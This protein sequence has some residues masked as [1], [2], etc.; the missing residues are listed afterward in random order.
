MIHK[1]IRRQIWAGEDVFQKQCSKMSR[2][3]F[4]TEKDANAL[5]RNLSEWVS[6]LQQ[7][8]KKESINPTQNNS[9]YNRLGPR[10][11]FVGKFSKLWNLFQSSGWPLQIGESVWGLTMGH[12]NV[13]AVWLQNPGNLRFVDCF[14]REIRLNPSCL[15]DFFQHIID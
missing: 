10:C 9:L 3:K 7:Q 5:L 11:Q 8:V 1:R 2:F 12:G 13:D 14:E 15:H 6:Y 4:L